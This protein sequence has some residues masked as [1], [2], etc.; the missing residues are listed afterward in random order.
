MSERARVLVVDDEAAILELARRALGA[1]GYEVDTAE[2]GERALACARAR[3][4][5]VIVS[6]VMM[7][8]LD[9]RDLVRAL[10]AD[11]AFTLVPVIFL[12]ARTTPADRVEGLRLGADD[13]LPKPF[14]LEELALRVANA[15]KHRRR[16]RHT[17]KLRAD[18]LERRAATSAPKLEIVD[19]PAV[20]GSLE[21]VALST[22]LSVFAIDGKS[23]LL[24]VRSGSEVGR[25]CLRDGRVVAARREGRLN[26][27]GREAILSI[28]GWCSG[29]FEYDSLEV[30]TEDEIQMSTTQLLVEAARRSAGG[31][32]QA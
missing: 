26:L 6:D 19:E 18:F 17:L 25:L 24:V 10:R 16:L 9:G 5:D 21:H 11:P 28:L 4:P 22:L 3:K 8:N 20:R 7:P 12:T 31:R 15:A 2:D 29:D 27:D 32:G 13:Y 23:G 14:H 1:R 30:E